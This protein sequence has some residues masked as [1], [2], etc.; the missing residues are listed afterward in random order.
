M[1]KKEKSNVV[2]FELRKKLQDAISS[3]SFFITITKFDEKARK[4]EHYYTLKQFPTDDIVPT[5]E[6]FAGQFVEDDLLSEEDLF[7]E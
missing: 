1:P 6:H 7:N 5:L 4:L 3:G 2:L